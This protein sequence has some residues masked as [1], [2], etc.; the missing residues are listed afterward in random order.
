[1]SHTFL[2]DGI[3]H[4]VSI[5]GRRGNYRIGDV[6]VALAP[7]PSGA[8]TLRCDDREYIAVVVAEGDWLH[9]HL[10]G[11]SY[12]LRYRDPVAALGDPAARAGSDIAKAPMPGLVLSV[13]VTPGQGV[14]AGATLVVI[15]SMK[16]QLAIIAE[17]HG[18]VE[19]VHV[20]A[21]QTFDRDAVLIT[22]S[23]VAVA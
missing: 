6:P 11:H 5:S 2:V 14:V 21:G 1:M 10:D 13:E 8:T 3:E 4:V 12:E 9:I 19:Q 18:I 22:L 16:M 15:E 23:P 7:L 17:R 20:A